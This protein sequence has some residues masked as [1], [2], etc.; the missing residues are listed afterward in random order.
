[1]ADASATGIQVLPWPLAANPATAGAPTLAD[2][3]TCLLL[4]GADLTTFV[5]AAKAANALTVWTFASARYSA[6]PRP[7]YPD[8]SGCAG[9]A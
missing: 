6:R 3:V 7:L 1:M 9:G 4:S 5:N 8:E 2:G